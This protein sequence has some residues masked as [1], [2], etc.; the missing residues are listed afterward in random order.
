MEVHQ[1]RYFIATA[2]ELSVTAAAKRLHISQPAMSRQ[3]QLLE[4]ELGIA[5]F[6]RVKK[7][8][9]L[10]EAGKFFLE[11]ARQIVCDIE[12]SAQQLQEQFGEARRTIR[13][14]LL[15]IFLDDIVGPAV[16]DMKKQFPNVGVSLFELSPRAQLDRLRDDDLDLALLGNLSEDDL[17]R[18]ETKS[19]MKNRMSVV[20]P[21]DHRMAGRKQISLKELAGDSFISLSDSAFPGRRQFFRGVC[22]SQG[23]DP[24]IVEEC[25]SLSLL[26]AAVSTGSGVALLPDHSRKLP[27]MGCIFVKL[28]TPVVYAEVLGVYKKDQNRGAVASLME[29]MT[30]A[31]E[32]IKHE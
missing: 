12:T 11:R 23:F 14:G 5:L 4:E 16:R 19:I 8:M 22:L 2:E 13:L 28:K 10:T 6:E 30:E 29:A 31:A 3:I 25:D 9:V 20:L 24:N 26:L 21:D 15:T 1:L 32:K 27:H 17:A 18:F 7:R